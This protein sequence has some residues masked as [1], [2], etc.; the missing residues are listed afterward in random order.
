[1]RIQ[2][3]K[4]LRST[5]PVLYHGSSRPFPGDVIIPQPDVT[6]VHHQ[7]HGTAEETAHQGNFVFASPDLATAY[8]YAFK[9]SAPL[10][11]GS[12]QPFMRGFDSYMLEDG[13]SV[14][15]AVIA[16]KDAFLEQARKAN[17]VVYRLP[18]HNDFSEV[19]DRRREPTREW[20]SRKAVALDDCEAIRVHSL[21]E[22]MEKGGQIFFLKK[23]GGI[24][25][26]VMSHEIKMHIEGQ[27]E[28]L[29]HKPKE[30]KKEASKRYM[31]ALKKMSEGEHPILEHYNAARGISPVD[32][33][34]G[35]FDA[36]HKPQVFSSE[37]GQGG[38][39]LGY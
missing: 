13:T 33:E 15:I 32:L 14:P 35:R 19:L 20:A 22:A 5:K 34:H 27:I 4:V 26:G 11:G 30:W 6:S 23:E 28:H 12:P 36:A 39:T 24:P 7:F 25:W 21:D 17:P 8:T 31:Q 37:P 18:A 38:A 10:P 29:L 2:W 1:M 16:N 3:P 9:L